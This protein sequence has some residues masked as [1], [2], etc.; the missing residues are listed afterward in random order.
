MKGFILWSIFA[1]FYILIIL[2]FQVS[3]QVIQPVTPNTPSGSND[4]SNGQQTTQSIL[5]TSLSL[6]KLGITDAS[7][8]EALTNMYGTLIGQPECVKKSMCTAGNYLHNLPGRDILFTMM[9][10]YVPQ[11]WGLL[12]DIFRVSVM[13]G[14][15]CEVYICNPES[16]QSQ[17]PSTASGPVTPVPSLPNFTPMPATKPSATVSPFTSSQQSN[18]IDD[19]DNTIH[20]TH[21]NSKF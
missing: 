12:Y 14:Q 16:T 8:R 2:L 21:S 3:A 7:A 9:S 20:K 17:F 4:P 5:P 19:N 11:E 13:Y 15:N 6:D 10:R 18:E 1:A